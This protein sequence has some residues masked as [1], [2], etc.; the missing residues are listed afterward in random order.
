MDTFVYGTSQLETL[1]LN[2]ETEKNILIHH[3]VL[4]SIIIDT[5][6]PQGTDSTFY[7]C[8]IQSTIHESSARKP[9][10]CFYCFGEIA[11]VSFSHNER[12]ISCVSK[13]G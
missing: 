4:I 2:K 10:N 11:D 7:V 9:E 1:R 6:L 5:D 3:T 8:D 12:I 13:E